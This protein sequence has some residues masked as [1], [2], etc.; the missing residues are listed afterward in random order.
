MQPPPASFEH[1]FQNIITIFTMF[2]FIVVETIYY[3][4][5]FHKIDIAL[6]ILFYFLVNNYFGGYVNDEIHMYEIFSK[7]FNI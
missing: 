5:S 1:V 2:M 7:I 6:Y 3:L 4:M